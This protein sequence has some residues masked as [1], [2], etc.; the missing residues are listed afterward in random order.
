MGWDKNTEYI[1]GELVNQIKV[2]LQYKSRCR[3]LRAD[4]VVFISARLSTSTTQFRPFHH[5]FGCMTPTSFAIR[6]NAARFPRPKF[7]TGTSL[8]SREKSY[9]CVTGPHYMQQLPSAQLAP[10]IRTTPF[11]VDKQSAQVPSPK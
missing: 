9:A 7:A 8:H 5:P 10:M 11:S 4:Q 6:S 2:P 3:V 1:A